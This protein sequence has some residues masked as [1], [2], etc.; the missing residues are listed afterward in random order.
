MS[1]TPAE[2]ARWEA[3]VP[4][5][6]RIAPARRVAHILPWAAASAGT[7]A[8]F[9]HL[10]FDPV[11]LWWGLERLGWLL[12]HMMPPSHGGALAVFGAALAE[13][14]AMALLSTV[15]AAV[16]ALPV[17]LACARSG[18]LPAPARFAVRRASDLVRGVD[19][20]VWA[21]VFVNVVGLGPFAGILALTLHNS[22][23]LGKLYSE[24]IENI[25]RRQLDGIRASGGS[26]FAVFRLGVLPQI[27]PVLLSQALYYFESNTRSATII[28]AVGAGGIGLLLTERIRLYRWDEVAFLILM[29]LAAVFVIDLL[30][31]RLRGLLIDGRRAPLVA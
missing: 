27:L 3:V 7:L 29:I 24:A 5:L 18:G 10:G 2:M 30:S 19:P 14:L 20:L 4:G 8:V 16:L 6:V 21:L 9:W 25:E 26:G 15:F 31:Q 22:A 23:D 28:G 13:T 1:A 17:G 12:G 11:A